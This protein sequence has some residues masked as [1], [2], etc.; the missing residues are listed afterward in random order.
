MPLPANGYLEVNGDGIFRGV[1]YAQTGTFSGKF[2]SDAVDVV[3]YI[4]IRDGAVTSYVMAAPQYNL[5]LT[6]DYWVEA[7]LAAYPGHDSLVSIVFPLA[8]Y[9]R[10]M[11]VV[12]SRNGVEIYRGRNA[13]EAGYYRYNAL[14]VDHYFAQT[15]AIEFFDVHE[16]AT[17]TTYKVWFEPQTDVAGGAGNSIMDF[18]PRG[19]NGRLALALFNGAIP[20]IMFGSRRL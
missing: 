4:N 6:P 2:E 15:H 17:P 3:D 10:Y 20:N 9:D 16:L 14:W 12:I 11:D 1:V 19:I 7:T 5:S 8:I 18:A 13:H